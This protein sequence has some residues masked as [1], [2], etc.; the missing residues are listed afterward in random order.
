MNML[1]NGLRWLADKQAAHA[2]VNIEYRRGG[3]SFKIVAWLGRT[4]VETTDESGIRILSH[5]TDVLI[6][7]KDLPITPTLGDEIVTNDLRYE[8]LELSGDGCWCWSDPFQ[9][10]Y[11]IHVRELT[12]QK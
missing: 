8:V 9:T 7:S 1:A 6:R 2:S 10:T 3:Q 4:K 11:R 12:K 5:I